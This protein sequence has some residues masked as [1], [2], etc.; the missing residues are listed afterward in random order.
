MVGGWRSLC[1]QDEEHL[2]RDCKGQTA[3]A[4]EAQVMILEKMIDFFFQDN[5]TFGTVPR[6]FGDHDAADKFRTLVSNFMY[7]GKTS[8]KEKSQVALYLK[9]L[10]SKLALCKSP[11]DLHKHMTQVN[12]GIIKAGIKQP[13]TR[14][15]K[16]RGSR[17]PEPLVEAE[18]KVNPADP[19]ALSSPDYS[20]SA[21]EGE[22]E[23]VI[24][25]EE[26]T[27]KEGREPQRSRTFTQ[28]TR[29]VPASRS[30]A[31]SPQKLRAR[32]RSPVI[33]KPTAKATPKKNS[34][35]TCFWKK[36]FSF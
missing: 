11:S 9:M 1:G 32:S 30:R 13:E 17:E 22:F 5:Y 15:A 35:W 16:S 27:E 28:E 25:E 2:R 31:P 4:Q 14:D 8:H 33:L 20:G 23:E 10:D 19:L 26:P 7:A 36:Y 6:I 34:A 18:S 21:D 3:E 24:K 12:A 29:K